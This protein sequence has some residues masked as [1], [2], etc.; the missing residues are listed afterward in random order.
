MQ[1]TV[2]G[3]LIIC[4]DGTDKDTLTLSDDG[5]YLYGK[6]DDKTKFKLT[7]KQ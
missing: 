3:H 5:K 4:S 1:Y 7:R 6:M 2:Q